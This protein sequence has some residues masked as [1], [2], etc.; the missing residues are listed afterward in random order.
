MRKL[1]QLTQFEMYTHLIV[2]RQNTP[3]HF[4]LSSCSKHNFTTSA[5]PSMPGSSGCQTS[6]NSQSSHAL[7]EVCPMHAYVGCFP[8]LSSNLFHFKLILEG[9]ARH[10]IS[11]KA[12]FVCFHWFSFDR[13]YCS[14]LPE[15]ISS[16]SKLW[17]IQVSSSS[18][19]VEIDI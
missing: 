9:H 13:Y 8:P 11:F 1:Q 15:E 6:G 4:S 5:H 14:K 17:E 18:I 16:P 12:I 2:R 3:R 7:A 10:E 19:L